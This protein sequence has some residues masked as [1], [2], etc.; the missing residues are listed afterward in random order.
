MVFDPGSLAEVESV[1][2]VFLLEDVVCAV[3]QAQRP[4]D[5]PSR[6]ERPAGRH[7]FWVEDVVVSL[8][9][10]DMCGLWVVCKPRIRRDVVDPAPDRDPRIPPLP[11]VVE[12]KLLPRIPDNRRLDQRPHRN[13]LGPKQPVEHVQNKHNHKHRLDNH[14]LDRKVVRNRLFLHNQSVIPGTKGGEEREGGGGREVMV[15]GTYCLVDQ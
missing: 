2:V 12:R 4:V 1:D 10:L 8:S 13:V 14:N 3:L 11:P 15:C 9:V 5:Y 6:K 7:V